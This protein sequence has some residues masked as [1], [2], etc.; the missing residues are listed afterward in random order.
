MPAL[1][2]SSFLLLGAA[3]AA[4]AGRAAVEKTC[5]AK[6][7][8][9]A[10][11]GATLLTKDSRRSK[12]KDSLA[13]SNAQ[14]QERSIRSGL[15][16]NSSCVKDLTSSWFSQEFKKKF[17]CAVWNTCNQ[18]VTLKCKNSECTQTL[19]D[20]GL[21]WLKCNGQVSTDFCD[22]KSQCKVAAAPAP[23]PPAPAPPGPAPPGPAPPGPA[24]PPPPPPPHQHQLGT[25]LLNLGRRRFCGP[26]TS[27]AACTECRC[28]PG[29][30]KL[31]KLHKSGWTKSGA[32]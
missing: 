5:P 19:G 8:E 18:D 30:R 1:W 6:P 26:T 29:T 17:K 4:A 3:A 11:A 10:P 16:V 14:G 27:T 12:R 15:L 22:D 25:N 23:A 7:L 9:K 20:G 31:V 28:K 32:Q 13:P 21:F 2:Y 24:P